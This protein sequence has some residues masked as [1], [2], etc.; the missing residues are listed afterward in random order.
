ML[1]KIIPDKSIFRV[2]SHVACTSL[3][4]DTA[5]DKGGSNEEVEALDVEDVERVGALY[6]LRVSYTCHV[7]PVGRTQFL[8]IICH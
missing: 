6:V 3:S 5:Y 2:V 1:T 4:I 7:Y 8:P